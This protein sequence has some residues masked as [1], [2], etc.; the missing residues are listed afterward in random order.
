M[1][2]SNN[3]DAGCCEDGANPRSPRPQQEHS[4]GTLSSNTVP[5]NCINTSQTK[6]LRVGIDSLYLSY[7]GELFEDKSIRLNQLKN[8]L[9]QIK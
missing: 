1:Q 4:Q 7:Q 6:I 2:D 3:Y 5:S 9:N 8:S